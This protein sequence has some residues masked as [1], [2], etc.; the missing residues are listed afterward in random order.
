LPAL[1][2]NGTTIHYQ[3]AGEGF[4]VVQVHGYT[5]NLNNWAPLKPSLSA[6]YRTIALDLRGHG[7][8]S[9][10]ALPE[11]YRLE[12]MAA[13][14][15]AVIEALGIEGCHL[16]GHSM[17][18]MVA[19]ELALSR[20]RLVRSLVLI[21]TTGE[22][23]VVARMEE[24]RRLAVIA[25]EQGL[26][27]VF[28]AQLGFSSLPGRLEAEPHLVAQWRREFLM[29]S[30]DAFIYCGRAMLERRPRYQELAGLAVPALI[31]CGESDS[32][33][34]E[35]SKRL[36]QAMSASRLAIMAGCGH[37]P[38]IE[39][40]DAFAALLLPFLAEAEA[41]APPERGV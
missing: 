22:A 34:L 41:A 33:F 29:T 30:V 10:P 17:G 16:M 32:F 13:D 23:P 11:D 36:H 27:A 25:R 3:E 38:H 28:E 6:G 2:V 1:E 4:P 5:G 20:P 7:L 40:P 39:E 31:A 19:Q 8:S 24:R 21:A 26:E 15:A 37:S 18:G 12:V 14:V 35:P 9:R